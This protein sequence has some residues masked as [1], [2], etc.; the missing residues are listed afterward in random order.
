LNWGSLMKFLTTLIAF[1]SYSEGDFVPD[2]SL[3]GLL[4]SGIISIVLSLGS[5]F[6]FK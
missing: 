5:F 6:A 1:V 3:I 2:L 4:P